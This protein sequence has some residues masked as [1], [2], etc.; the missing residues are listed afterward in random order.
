MI[1]VCFICGRQRVL[2]VWLE[3]LDFT[4]L[5]VTHGLCLNCLEKEI[6]KLDNE[7]EKDDSIL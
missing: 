2:G 6:E 1:T 5:N 4:D 7:G 3:R